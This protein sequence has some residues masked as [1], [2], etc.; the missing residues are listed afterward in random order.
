MGGARSL[1]V[2]ASAS[3]RF[4]HTLRPRRSARTD[5][6]RREGPRGCR[7]P[8]P[9]RPRA[10]ATM[11]AYG[12]P[13]RR[14]EQST[15]VVR[16]SGGAA[17]PSAWRREAT[18]A[19][20][21]AT[22][23]AENGSSR[24]SSPGSAR[25]SGGQGTRESEALPLAAR[26]ADARLPDLRIET[27]RKP[28]DVVLEGGQPDGPAGNPVVAPEAAR[29]ER[30]V[31]SHRPGEQRRVLRQIADEAAPPG[32]RQIGE[33]R[34]VQRATCPTSPDRRPGSPARACSSRSRP[35]P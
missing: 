8:R 9:S 22:S 2:R 3:G 13:A 4:G 35:G 7:F 20:S 21:V 28:G 24:T 5:P 17:G 33:R 6:R 10:R 16:C 14:C 11:S 23:T 34:A 18:M 25:R 26:D 19:A 27:L 32:G 1:T 30:D 15:V 29:I 31:P 12:N